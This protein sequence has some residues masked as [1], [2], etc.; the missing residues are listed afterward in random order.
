VKD[1]TYPFASGSKVE[2][3]TGENEVSLRSMGALLKTADVITAIGHEQDAV[4]RRCGSLF[5]CV[6][7]DWLVSNDNLTR[8]TRQLS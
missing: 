8:S 7:S 4:A 6:Q 1:S 5:V 2:S 3:S